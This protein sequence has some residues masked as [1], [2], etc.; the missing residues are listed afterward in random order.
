MWLLQLN[1]KYY[2]GKGVAKGGCKRNQGEK[3]NIKRRKVV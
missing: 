3:E 2:R 1:P